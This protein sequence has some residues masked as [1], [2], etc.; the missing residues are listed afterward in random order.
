[1][2]PWPE[3]GAFVRGPGEFRKRLMAEA[4][5][6]RFGMALLAGDLHAAEEVAME[7]LGLSL[8]EAVLYELWSGRRCIASAGCG[9]RARS[10]WRTSISRRRS[11][12][13]CSCWRTRRR[14]S[15]ER[16]L[17]GW[18]CSRRPRESST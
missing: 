3:A 8:G 15:P 18:R 12:P 7:T 4:L 6:D 1:M 16:A 5:S 13:A 2:R 14:V 17:G 11:P 10:A 9:P